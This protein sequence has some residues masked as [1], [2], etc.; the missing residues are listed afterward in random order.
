MYTFGRGESAW[1]PAEGQSCWEGGLEGSCW[2]LSAVGSQANRRLIGNLD[3]RLTMRREGNACD[4][5]QADRL[6]DRIVRWWADQSREGRLR[7]RASRAVEE[8]AQV[9]LQ[10]ADGERVRQLAGLRRAQT[11]S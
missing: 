5:R 8:G 9:R 1:R 3:S 2:Y 10:A 4:Y 11:T 6:A 7:Q